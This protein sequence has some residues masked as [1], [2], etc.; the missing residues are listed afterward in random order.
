MPSV[1]YVVPSGS[2]LMRLSWYVLKRWKHSTNLVVHVCSNQL[3]QPPMEGTGQTSKELAWPS[4][5]QWSEC[6]TRGLQTDSVLLTST[7]TK[8][9]RLS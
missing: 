7:M 4:A 9:A 2:H 5:F 3:T 6:M 1:S 8:M